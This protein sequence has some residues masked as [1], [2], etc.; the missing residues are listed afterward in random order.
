MPVEGFKFQLHP[1]FIHALVCRSS[2]RRAGKP[3]H[4]FQHFPKLFCKHA[5][6]CGHLRYRNKSSSLTQS[7]AAVCIVALLLPTFCFMDTPAA[8]LLTLKL[9]ISSQKADF[10]LPLLHS[11]VHFV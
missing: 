9:R 7:L 11:D 3:L 10:E 2:Q 6:S 5:D 8:A 4:F 1:G